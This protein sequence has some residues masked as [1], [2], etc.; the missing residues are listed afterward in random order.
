[1]PTATIQ[2]NV[3]HGYRRAASEFAF[4]N[5]RATDAMRNATEDSA[6][7]VAGEAYEAI[8]K[9]TRRTALTIDK[10][11]VEAT[12]DGAIA[13]VGSS[14]K[15]AV[16]LEDGSRAHVIRA[17]NGALRFIHNGQVIYRKEV[18]HPGTSPY[19]WMS[20]AFTL[21]IFPS[22]R[23]YD[24]EVAEAYRTTLGIAL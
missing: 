3:R 4:A 21:S 11:E 13:Y 12:P 9:R 7:L 18:F 5:H 10:T 1:M 15:I 16:I 24:R 2:I 6:S 17:H 23:I 14:D 22:Q 20:R 19:L 8:P